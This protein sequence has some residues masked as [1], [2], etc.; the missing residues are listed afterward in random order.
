MDNND[1][2][3]RLDKIYKV[4]QSIQIELHKKKNLFCPGC[5]TLNDT[6][7]SMERVIRNIDHIRDD[8][9]VNTILEKVDKIEKIVV[10][11]R[12]DYLND[13]LGGTI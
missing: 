13:K 11:S 8:N 2:L 5:R 7:D 1:I 6:M 12:I 3:E 9:K 4:L 10:G